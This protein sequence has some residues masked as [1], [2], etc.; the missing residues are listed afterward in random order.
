MRRSTSLLGISLVVL[1]ASPSRAESGADEP[2]T[3]S[4]PEAVEAQLRAGVAVTV[5]T[6]NR[7]GATVRVR[8]A[9]PDR[10]TVRIFDA[11]G[12]LVAERPPLRIA[13]GSLSGAPMDLAAGQAIDE[14]VWILDRC[15]PLPVG[16]Y[17]VEL[18]LDAPTE[19]GVFP[20]RATR[21]LALTVRDD[22][23]VPERNLNV[24]VPRE[25]VLDVGGKPE[26]G[27][28]V[29]IQNAGCRDETIPLPAA[30]S[31]SMT[32]TGPDGKDIPCQL[33]KP[34]EL[35]SITLT[36]T[37]NEW[38]SLFP[39]SGRCQVTLPANLSAVPAT[40]T[41]KMKY[42]GPGW[43]KPPLVLD[44]VVKLKLVI[45]PHSSGGLRRP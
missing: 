38:S 33:P 29:K 40:Y 7:S 34:A 39:I 8:P 13:A 37:H 16:R 5:V 36:P 3:F 10:V 23:P 17:G 15:D 11:S 43:G 18:R 27:V 14:R 21:S 31:V 32:V 35:R 12:K 25:T 4:V 19:R 9:R 26:F 41:V 44:A 28:W 45:Q 2:V 24:F 42:D 6:K 20:L 1:L 22:T 30:E